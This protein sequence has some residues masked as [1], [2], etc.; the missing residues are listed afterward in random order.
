MTPLDR[1]LVRD[2]W[3][4]KGQAAA[5]GAVIAVGVLL[6][7]MMSGLVTSLDETRRAYYERYRL[8][9]VFAPVKR[10][11]RHL[12]AEL[13]ALPS[14]AAVEGR[15]TGHA[16]IDLPGLDIPLRA[17]V[18]SLP[19]FHTPR[20]NG[21][22]L[23]A[24]RAP[25][26]DRHDE[27]LLLKGFAEAHS[28]RPGDTLDITLNGARHTLRI[29]GLAQAPEFLYTTAP[30]ELMSDDA[31]YGVMWISMQTLAAAYDLEGAFNEALLSIGRGAEPSAV[32]HAVD[33]LLE[34]YGG[35]GAY[36]VADHGSNRFISEEIASL[37]A[38]AAAVPPIFLAVAAFLL[39]IVIFRMVEAE[40]GQIGLL[41]AFGYS[42]LETAGHYFK[43]ILAIAAGGATV[44][45]VLGILAGRALIDLYLLY[46]KFPFLIF[47]LDP[48]SFIAA[49]SVSIGAASAGGVTVL[50]RVFR[51]TPAAAMQPP[52]PPRY[53]P[54]GDLARSLQS[55]LDQPSRMVVRR[56]TRQPGRMAGA[57][58]GIAAGMALSVAMIGI[59]NG[60]NQ[61]ID[62]TF[63][64]ID[65][66]DVSVTFNEPLSDTALDNLRRMP[67][68]LDAQPARHVSAVLR[69]GV[70]R[71]LGVVSGLT[72]DAR[73]YRA[74][75]SG[76]AA[77]P[78]Q[79]GGI[80][81]AEALADI[82]QVRVGDLLTLEVREGRRPTLRI[83][84]TGIAQTLLGSP[85]YMELS[86]LNRALGEPNRVSGA[87]LRL[88]ST[89]QNAV[90]RGL[91]DMPAVASVSLKQDAR[92][93][94][95]T[96]MDSGAGAMRYIMMAVAGIITFGIIY[97]AARIAYAERARDLASL[98]V[99]GF[100][101]REAAFVLLG[102]LALVTLAALPLGAVL[103]YYLSFAVAAGF[104]TDLYQI[105]ATV[106]PAGYGAAA[107]AVIAA[108][109]L[110][111]WLVK[112]DLDRTDL[113][114]ALKARE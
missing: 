110:S 53:R 3:R 7:V 107:L 103:G 87:Y 18:V 33:R 14:V 72:T 68:V 41:K 111:G 113:V 67:G 44:G 96:Q 114:S 55:V 94:L 86:A 30:G 19:E 60:F 84:V 83:P 54:L 22:Y 23:S 85:A 34:P 75:D 97:N 59:M 93:A 38:T 42:N 37:R 43:L 61:A 28:L 57:A 21:F 70:Q 82:L 81:L 64:V 16:L 109:T 32:I 10:A 89:H 48:V 65:Q 5:I 1:K 51:L 102:E 52:A 58:G 71:H 26:S 15:I 101:H 104:S 39:Y 112:R 108:A 79:A 69:H 45:C 12:L 78:L 9:D 31:R 36:T 20:L 77:V 76:M 24:G 73:L 95:Q 49:F 91:K 25:Q 27:I 88:D 90:Y 17:R 62:L 35:F 92:N 106:Q 66:S 46:F 50:R 100:S 99:I 63:N 98:R 80:V 29:V 47:Q 56:L 13:S 8:A 4:I 2:L 6:L 40:R 105:P 11:P 74:V